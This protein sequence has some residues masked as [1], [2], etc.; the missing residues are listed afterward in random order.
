[1]GEFI[2]AALQE[3]FTRT[4]TEKIDPLALKMFYQQYPGPASHLPCFVAARRNW[5]ESGNDSTTLLETS[6]PQVFRY[7]QQPLL[8]ADNVR[9]LRDDGAVSTEDL[10]LHSF[11]ELT[12]PAYKVVEADKSRVHP[13]HLWWKPGPQ[14]ELPEACP[15]FF[16]ESGQWGLGDEQTPPEKWREI[17]NHIVFTFSDADNWDVENVDF[18][19]GGADPQDFYQTDAWAGFDPNNDEHRSYEEMS[20]SY[21]ESCEREIRKVIGNTVP[22][23]FSWE[24]L[25]RFIP[26]G[27]QIVAVTPEYKSLRNRKP[28]NLMLILS[29]DEIIRLRLYQASEHRARR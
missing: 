9:V 11:L 26:E 10:G 22:D 8:L 25:S 7:D 2:Q 3:Y 1:M 6:L 17:C 18:T 23:N 15:Q 4:P 14:I 5:Y 28:V 12:G 13:R 27:L 21:R 29:N 24:D 16:H 19:V 20:D